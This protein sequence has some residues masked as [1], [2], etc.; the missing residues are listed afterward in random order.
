[1][2]KRRP[3]NDISRADQR[4]LA[5]PTL[6]GRMRSALALAHLAFMP[7]NTAQGVATHAGRSLWG[8]GAGAMVGRWVAVGLVE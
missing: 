5:V 3:D 4:P 1:M 2:Y 7:R 8:D 6:V